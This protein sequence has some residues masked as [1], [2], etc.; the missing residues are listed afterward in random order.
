MNTLDHEN[1]AVYD[2]D[3]GHYGFCG[4]YEE[5]TPSQTPT[6]SDPHPGRFAL[7]ADEDQMN[8]EVRCEVARLQRELGAA[9]KSFGITPGIH[10][11]GDASSLVVT[12]LPWQVSAFVD[13]GGPTLRLIAHRA[14]TLAVA[15]TE[16]VSEYSAAV[17]IE[18][19]RALDSVAVSAE[20]VAA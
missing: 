18:R 9:L 3:F 19:A 13:C 7:D 17:A 12:A 16:V 4:G 5:P 8:Q 2:A 10:W 1:A 20:Q 11:S 14:P 15:V 6:A